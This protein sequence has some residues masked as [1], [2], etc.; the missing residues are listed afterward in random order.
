VE[1]K[2][3]REFTGRLDAYYKSYYNL[4]VKDPSTENLGNMELGDAKGI[5]LLLR[6]DW[7]EKFFGWISYAYSKSER[8]G[9]PTNNW[10]TYQYDQ[11]NILTLVASYSITPPWSFGIKL[12]YNSGP[13]VQSLQGRYELNNV[14]YPVFSNTYDQRLEDYLRLDVR[15]D[16]SWRYEGWRLN[17]YIETLNLLNRANPAGVTYNKDYS[18]AETINNLPRLPYFGVEVEF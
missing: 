15:M 10:Y 1:K 14:W 11:P 7:G 13:L 2:F 3:S 8:F 18:Q 6:E 12:H 4:V 17:A 5:E 16:Y 9:P